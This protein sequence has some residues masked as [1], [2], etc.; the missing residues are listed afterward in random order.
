MRANSPY[1]VGLTGGVSTGKTTILMCLKELGAVVFSADDASHRLTA[2]GGEALPAIRETFGDA[3]FLPDGALDRRALGEIVFRD[4]ACRRA[5]EAIIHPAVQRNTLHE[6]EEAGEEG[7]R[8]VFMEV[9]LLYETG[10]D[11]LCGEVWVAYLDAESQTLRLMNRDRLTREQAEAR[12][13][14]QMPLE[15]K[16]KR[17]DVVIKTDK[18]VPEVQK[19]VAHLY[20]DL[21]KRVGR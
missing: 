17:A 13:Q 16:A 4:P 21:V 3:V 1:V 11:A 14:S 8:I 10:M 15:E 12:I 20:R 2:P 7:A 9:P 6:I 19:E 5:L 18:P